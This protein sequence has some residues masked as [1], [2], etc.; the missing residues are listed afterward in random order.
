M[1][2]SK[3]LQQGRKSRLLLVTVA[4]CIVGA[5]LIGANAQAA[6]GTGVASNGLFQPG[7]EP[8]GNSNAGAGQHGSGEC[9]P[10]AH[11]AIQRPAP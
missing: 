11:T 5:L 7:T 6:V 3:G 8:G 2:A 10:T 9:A 4:I 1:R